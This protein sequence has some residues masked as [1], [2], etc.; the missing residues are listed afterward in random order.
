MYKIIITALLILTLFGC[1]KQKEKSI[2]LD[3][4]TSFKTEI[5]TIIK[6]AIDT[7]IK[8]AKD[9][10][11]IIWKDTLIKTEKY[12]EPIKLKKIIFHTS[13]CNG[14]CPAYHLQI[15]S[16]KK[17]KLFAEVVFKISGNKKIEHK[18][19][20]NKIGYFSGS[21]SDTTF[22][23]LITHLQICKIDK[24]TFDGSTCCDAP[25]RTIIVYYNG[26][27]KYLK[28]MFPPDEAKHLID[29][30]KNICE[31]SK[32]LKTEKFNIEK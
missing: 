6:T 15:D 16:D 18:L 25:L 27:R 4:D 5:D 17:I 19:D 30:L 13:I 3:K 11:T 8:T 10:A 23:N 2:K 31:Y 14:L 21:I 1:G 20:S 28:S 32:L 7:T 9:T 26:K 22:K 12:Y 24:L 29:Y